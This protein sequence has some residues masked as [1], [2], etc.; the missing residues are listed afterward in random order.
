MR[1][2]SSHLLASH[3]V[4]GSHLLACHWLASHVVSSR[5]CDGRRC[6]SA[7]V[8]RDGRIRSLLGV[9][10]VMSALVDSISS[11]SSHEE[12]LNDQVDQDKEARGRYR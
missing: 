10:V 9:V 2:L 11:V 3:V 8:S 7:S 12:E 6:S 1:L 4:G 5:T